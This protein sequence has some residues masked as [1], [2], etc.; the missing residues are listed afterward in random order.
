[1]DDE[2]KIHAMFGFWCFMWLLGQP[3]GQAD[4]DIEIG[5]YVLEGGA[6]GL[7]FHGRLVR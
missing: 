3:Q 4:S 7:F 5:V 2:R 1:M 6:I